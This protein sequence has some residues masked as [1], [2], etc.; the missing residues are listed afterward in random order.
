M[1][2]K[3]LSLLL[4]AAILLSLMAGLSGCGSGDQPKLSGAYYARPENTRRVKDWYDLFKKIYKDNQSVPQTALDK[5]QG[6]IDNYVKEYWDVAESNWESWIDAFDKNGSLSKYPWPSESDREKISNNYK[7]EIY[8]YLQAVFRSLSRDMYFDILNQREK[9]YKQLAAQLNTVYTLTFKEDF[10]S[11]EAKWANAYVKLAPLSDE[12]TAKAWTIRLDG[13]AKGQMKFTLRAR[14]GGLPDEGRVL[15][16]RK[17][18]GGRQG[19][20]E[21]EAQALCRNRNE[22]YRKYKDQ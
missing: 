8:E 19:C 7:A 2:R 6:E 16:N 14:N 9:E 21:C 10:D 13:E 15:Q 1:K 3:I 12:T 5:M 18:L 4:A 20:V 11:E 17:G 22:R